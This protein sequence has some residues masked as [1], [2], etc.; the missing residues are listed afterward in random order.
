MNSVHLIGRIANDLESNVMVKQDQTVLKINLAVKRKYK[1]D[2]A[3]FISCVA[4]GKTAEN[5]VNFFRK[6]NLIAVNG[7]IQSGSYEA[8][9]KTRRYT[10][11]VIIDEFFFLEPKGSNNKNVTKNEFKLE[12]DTLMEEMEGD[13]DIPF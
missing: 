10:T 4:F 13:G 7:R 5:I 8:K 9:D 6:G 11:D 12:N 2:E 3:D 1:K